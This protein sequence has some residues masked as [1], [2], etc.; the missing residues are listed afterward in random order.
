MCEKMMSLSSY[1]YS[2]FPAPQG[3]MQD[4]KIRNLTVQDDWLEVPDSY[5]IGQILQALVSVDIHVDK[6]WFRIENSRKLQRF[7]EYPDSDRCS[8]PDGAEWISISRLIVAK[9]PNRCSTYPMN[10][11]LDL[12]N[13]A[14]SAQEF[15][16]SQMNIPEN[17]TCFTWSAGR[18]QV[19]IERIDAKD[20]TYHDCK[21]DYEESGESESSE[22][23]SDRSQDSDE[24]SEDSFVDD[25]D[26][27][28]V[29]SDDE[30]VPVNTKRRTR[31]RYESSSS[32]NIPFNLRATG[33]RSRIASE[34]DDL[35]DNR[36]Y[37]KL[38]RK[39]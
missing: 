1:S 28:S 15:R 2:L 20:R 21:S 24:E 16:N 33:K 38:S 22:I 4:F 6:N 34:L 37:R 3:T 10:S 23:A 5:S 27:I 36:N 35:I 9:I 30:F 8:R 29:S 12:Q 13:L 31:K 32:N 39:C 19:D 18:G 25:V 14:R 26:T 11:I 17:I 7:Y